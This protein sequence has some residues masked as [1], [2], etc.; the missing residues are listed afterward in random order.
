MAYTTTAKI[1]QEAGF[2]NNSNV[3][4]TVIGQ[5][6]T[7][8]YNLVRSFVS[9]RY[10][11]TLFSG[12][13]FTGSQAESVL[14][15][16]EL[17]IAAGYLISSEFQGQPRGDSEGKQKVADAMSILKQIASGELRL[18][19]AD[20]SL[21]SSGAESSHEGGSAEYT[22]PARETAEA[23]FSEKKFSVNDRY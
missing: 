17:L 8:A 14:E 19:G 15:Q 13:N 11:I 5:Y 6:Q 12:A 4:D 1:R 20:G 3:S 9:G 10:D 18:V 7:R 22:A 16:C 23:E 21:Y 2:Q